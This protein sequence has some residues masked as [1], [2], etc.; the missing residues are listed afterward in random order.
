[1][2]LNFEKYVWIIPYLGTVLCWIALPFPAACFENVIYNHQIVSW[3]W[4]FFEDIFNLLRISDFY[5]YPLQ[6]NTSIAVS[7]INVI[8]LIFLSAV[9]IVKRK[10][11]KKGT[12]KSTKYILLP[13][14]IIM[15]TMIWMIS[16]EI[17]EQ[18]IW[19]IS[20]W[21]RYVPCFGL[22]GLL[23]GAILVIVGIILIKVVKNRNLNE[24]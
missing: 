19:S 6:I 13:S 4:G 17:S 23:F 18:Q 22:L 5:S 15:S 1:M 10:Q 24:L 2:N 20:F 14:I 8:S 11:V 7:I 12:L 3:M 9:L 21:G 16:M